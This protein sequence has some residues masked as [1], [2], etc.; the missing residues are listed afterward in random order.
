MRKC[1][2]EQSVFTAPINCPVLESY[3]CDASPAPRHPIG[4]D[5][6]ARRKKQLSSNVPVRIPTSRCGFPPLYLVNR[7]SEPC[8]HFFKTFA[9]PDAS[10]S[11]LR[12]LPRLRF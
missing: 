12:V 10:C 6:G 7:R 5:P 1:D 9:T 2:A 4:T 8:T 3:T 11:R